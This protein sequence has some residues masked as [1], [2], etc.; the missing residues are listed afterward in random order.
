ML[1]PRM[2]APWIRGGNTNTLQMGALGP[3]HI[4]AVAFIRGMSPDPLQRAGVLPMNPLTPVPVVSLQT[5][6]DWAP[7]AAFTNLNVPPSLLI[8][9]SVVKG[10]S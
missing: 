6:L 7:P 3:N 2:Y 9:T 8:A 5:P 1:D 10:V 4:Q